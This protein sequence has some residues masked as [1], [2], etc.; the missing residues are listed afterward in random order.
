M[1]NSTSTTIAN[2]KFSGSGDIWK[3]DFNNNFFEVKKSLFSRFLDF[4][5]NLA[6]KDDTRTQVTKTIYRIDKRSSRIR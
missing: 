6:R 4:L 5:V 2:N 3:V 1:N